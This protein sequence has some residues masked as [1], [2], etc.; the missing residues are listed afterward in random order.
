MNLFSLNKISI[1]NFKIFQDTQ[2]FELNPVTILTG[3]NGS[4]KS[5]LLKFLKIL[6]SNKDNF[7]AKL[8]FNAPETN[9][10]GFETAK[11]FES[12]SN[13]ILLA[14]EFE[15]SKIFFSEGFL[16]EKIKFEIEYFWNGEYCEVG[17]LT[18][19]D[20]DYEIISFI[21]SNEH[22]R[23]YDND[24]YI[25]FFNIKKYIDSIQFKKKWKKHFC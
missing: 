14:L 8:Q 2:Q 1:K 4:G 3:T 19:K 15:Q 17:K 10:T 7:L 5:S 25:I 24:A 13:K 9:I 20:G 18:I 23:I 21:N 6:E 11:N 22:Y 16:S 12:D